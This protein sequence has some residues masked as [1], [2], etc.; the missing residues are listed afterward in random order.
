[1]YGYE[2]VR[3]P[4]CECG[5]VAFDKRGAETKRNVLINTGQEKY[6]RIYVCEYS[7]SWHLT[8]KDYKGERRMKQ[9]RYGKQRQKRWRGYQ[10]KYY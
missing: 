10:H 5:K 2:A 6:L 1:M 8:S 3:Y 9:L 7:G 4:R